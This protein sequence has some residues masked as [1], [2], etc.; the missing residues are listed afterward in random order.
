M[1]GCGSEGLVEDKIKAGEALLAQRGSK[2]TQLRNTGEENQP[3]RR[4]NILLDQDS[5]DNLKKIMKA[6]GDATYTAG[7]KRA[8]A[9]LAFIEEQARAGLDVYL[10]E[11]GRK[12]SGIKKI[13]TAT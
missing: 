2:N 1:Y 10:V 6:H 7:I 8:L 13:V 12:I 4:L 11:R 3:V 9:Y 5:F